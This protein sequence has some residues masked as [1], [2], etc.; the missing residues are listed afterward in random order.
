MISEWLSKR[1]DVFSLDR[2]QDGFAYLATLTTEQFKLCCFIDGLDEFEGDFEAMIELFKGV[3]KLP[4]IKI[5]VSSRPWLVFEETFENNPGLR[6]QDLTYKDIRLYVSDKLESHS[7]MQQLSKSKP[8]LAA[9]FA[10]EIVS[11]AN[12]FFLSYI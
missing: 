6:L 1:D 9:A 8:V 7:K 12:G 3:S 5:C 2:L 11:K 4:N 10:K